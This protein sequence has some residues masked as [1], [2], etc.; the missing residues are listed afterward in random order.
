MIHD[1]KLARGIDRQLGESAI[2]LP[3]VQAAFVGQVLQITAPTHL[4]EHAKVVALREEQLQDKAP[5]VHHLFGV[6]VDNHSLR[7]GECAGGLQNPLLLHLYQTDSTGPDRLD[8]GV[9]AKCGDLD[10]CSVGGI[11]YG[12]ICWHRNLSAINRNSYIRHNPGSSCDNWLCEDTTG[13][14]NAADLIRLPLYYNRYS[15]ENQLRIA[16]LVRNS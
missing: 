7:H 3:V 15:Y 8:S 9:R 12:A 14:T 13:T 4:A 2:I 6:C 10:L 16:S 1:K 11:Q 5:R